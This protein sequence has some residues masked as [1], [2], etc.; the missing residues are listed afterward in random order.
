MAQ[1]VCKSCAGKVGATQAGSVGIVARYSCRAQIGH[2]NVVSRDES[3]RR[4]GK[5]LV[6]VVILAAVAAIATWPRQPSDEHKRPKE[7]TKQ[8]DRGKE[9]CREQS[10][11]RIPAPESG[12]CPGKK[13][14]GDPKCNAGQIGED[15]ESFQNV[16]QHFN[17]ELGY[18]LDATQY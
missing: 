18:L 17:H 8:N 11:Q 5:T 15:I 14:D 10:L 6:L 9:D 4:S 12:L 7:D 1:P 2:T 16:G 13:D 3:A